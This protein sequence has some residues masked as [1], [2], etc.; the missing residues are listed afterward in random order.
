VRAITLHGECTAC[1][2]CCMPQDGFLYHSHC[3]DGV[4][5]GRNALL[6]WFMP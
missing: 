3:R 4:G 1:A 6:A 2:E 5:A